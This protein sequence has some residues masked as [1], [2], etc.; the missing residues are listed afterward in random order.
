MTQ[1][2]ALE[3]RSRWDIVF[4]TLAA[5][6]IAAVQVGKLPPA[7]PL[8][9]AELGISLVTAG[10]AASLFNI[11]GALGGIFIGAQVEHFGIRRT[12]LICLAILSLGAMIDALAPFAG[13]LM[14]GRGFVSLGFV[15][16]AVTAPR[17]VAAA[18]ALERHH[19]LAL[20]LWSIYMPAGMA[21]AMFLAPL[22]IPDLGWRGFWLICALAGIVFIP[23]YWAASTPNRW[24]SPPKSASR[25][26]LRN[27]RISLNRPAP[28]IMA[29]CFALYS[30]QWLAVMVWLPTF[31]IERHGMSNGEA[32]MGT[33]VVVA[34]NIL[35]NL[36]AGW[37]LHRGAAR[38][39]LIVIA[40]LDHGRD[41]RRDL[42]RRGGGQL[43][44]AAGRH[45][46]LRRRHSAGL[47]VL[48]LPAA[49]PR[50][51][52]D[53]HY[54]RRRHSGLQQRQPAGSAGDGGSGQCRGLVEQLV[55][56][57]RLC[58]GRLRPRRL[59][60]PH[61]STLKPQINRPVPA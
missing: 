60:W 35:G 18:A 11:A 58:P 6:I 21:L 10:W 47:G 44:P 51:G 38:W 33:A 49:R 3:G 34:V 7:I 39:L 54:F 26:V 32:A 23:L 14:L 17:L 56:A 25:N 42:F 59:A 15:G 48:R 27:I 19:G 61:R 29:G 8:L 57:G 4:L 50:T 24:T 2:A 55:A 9:R 40:C 41:R 16:I 30:I 52:P 28:W 43:A 5:G 37:L 53:R 46:F 36:T 45:I 13:W 1:T 22:L 20:G 12:I 31:L